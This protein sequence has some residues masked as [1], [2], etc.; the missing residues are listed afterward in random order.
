MIDDLESRARLY[1]LSLREL[2]KCELDVKTILE[3]FIP[4]RSDELYNHIVFKILDKIYLGGV[5]CE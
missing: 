5:D 3:Q 4:H 1:G 2:S